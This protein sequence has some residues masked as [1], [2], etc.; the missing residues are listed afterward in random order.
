[1]P[2][3]Q[4]MMTIFKDEEILSTIRNATEDQEVVRYLNEV[5]A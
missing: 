2:W 5:F 3:L 4:K 1:M